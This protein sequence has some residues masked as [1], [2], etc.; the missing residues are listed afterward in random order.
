M[1]NMVN[2][3]KA[4]VFQWIAALAL[5]MLS[6]A[7][8]SA[9]GDKAQINIDITGTL[10]AT[11]SCTFDQGGTLSVNFGIIELKKNRDN[12]LSLFGDYKKPL[13]SDFSCTGDSSGLLQM[14]FES[15]SGSYET[16][17]GKNVL[18]TDK[19][20]IG[21]ELLVNGNPQSMAE[22]FDVDTENQPT[23]QAQIVQVSS[24]N[25]S[26]VKTDDTFSASGTLT[27]AFN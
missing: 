26:N 17:N 20:V 7:T 15:S 21:I 13:T 6:P 16:Y 23:L 24:E 18:G 11:G 9:S 2:L 4:N 8:Y 19:G 14:K 5:M 27:L 25:T 1:K 10:V 22:W 12:T 3:S